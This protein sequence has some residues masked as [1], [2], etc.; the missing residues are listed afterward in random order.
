[1]QKEEEKSAEKSGFDEWLEKGKKLIDNASDYLEDKIEDVKESETYQKVSEFVEDKTAEFK[2]G[3]M[4]QKLNAYK[5]SVAQNA[6]EV[7]DKAK[8]AVG[9]LADDVE[10]LIGKVKTSIKGK[11][12]ST[13]PENVT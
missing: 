11:D 10:E 4:E 1:M 5:D 8:S 2:S 7:F 6:E 9:N 13:P 3:E 12:G